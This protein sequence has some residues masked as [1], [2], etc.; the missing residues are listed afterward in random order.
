LASSKAQGA[1]GSSGGLPASSSSSSP[2][3]VRSS[4]AISAG[5]TPESPSWIGPG[6]PIRCPWTSGTRPAALT[7][8][9][10]SPC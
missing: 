10:A 4:S 2:S 3:N 7:C 6:C 9:P 8:A 1:T 5:G